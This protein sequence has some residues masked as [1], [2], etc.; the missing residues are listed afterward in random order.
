MFTRVA[1][2]VATVAMPRWETGGKRTGAHRRR[3]CRRVRGRPSAV[4]RGRSPVRRRA[5]GTGRASKSLFGGCPPTRSAAEGRGARG[6]RVQG[7]ATARRS[8]EAG[9]GRVGGRSARCWRAPAGVRQANWRRM[10]GES[11]VSTV[12][13]NRVNLNRWSTTTSWGS[14]VGHRQ[15]RASLDGVRG[16][17]VKAVSPAKAGAE[18][19]DAP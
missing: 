5:A 16:A 6:R 12:I 15:T 7:R 19:S 14:G 3:P 11:P 4:Q 9:R 18:R 13:R 8:A 1:S 17:G 2:T 10:A